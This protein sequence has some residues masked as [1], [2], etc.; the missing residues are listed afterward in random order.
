MEKLHHRKNPI[1]IAM[2]EKDIFQLALASELSKKP[3]NLLIAPMK[4]GSYKLKDYH[5]RP[6]EKTRLV[7]IY[8]NL[9]TGNIYSRIYMT[10]TPTEIPTVCLGPFED[11]KKIGH[12]DGVS[13]FPFKGN[14]NITTAFGTI[15]S[16]ELHTLPSLQSVFGTVQD[17]SY[18]VR[19]SS[20]ML[21][22]L[23]N[24]APESLIR[25]IKL[26]DNLFSNESEDQIFAHITSPNESLD[27]YPEIGLY[28]FVVTNSPNYATIHNNWNW[29]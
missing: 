12:K 6:N 23:W 16:R 27:L 29:I 14:N 24:T 17:L 28:G 8:E 13:I 25:R 4:K 15:N 22:Y 3:K 11:I 19:P 5:F 18:I 10:P 26:Y 20:Y 1:E 7:E 2:Y 21:S 9:L